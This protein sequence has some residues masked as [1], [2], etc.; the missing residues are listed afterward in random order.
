MTSLI[1]FVLILLLNSLSSN[2]NH[3]CSI[4]C[5]DVIDPV[6]VDTTIYDLFLPNLLR[7]GPADGVCLGGKDK[8]VVNGT[9]FGLPPKCVCLQ[10]YKGEDIKPGEGPQCPNH[11]SAA[12]DE[13]MLDNLM[14]N[15]EL[16][17]DVAPADG[18]CPEGTFKWI[19]STW[20]FHVPKDIC[21]CIVEYFSPEVT[22]IDMEND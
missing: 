2:A 3:K 19:I 6:D 5:P 22:C 21:V 15:Y 11:L 18:W 4:I 7:D 20:Q 16:L 17:G 13:T 1:T 14:R 8:W 12:M 9:A 10:Y